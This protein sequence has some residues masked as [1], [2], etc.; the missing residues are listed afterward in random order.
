MLRF[1][2]AGIIQLEKTE[3][4]PQKREIPAK[5][6]SIMRILAEIISEYVAS[7]HPSALVFYLAFF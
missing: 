7:I 1:F 6:T 2:Y 4:Y 5:P 3:V